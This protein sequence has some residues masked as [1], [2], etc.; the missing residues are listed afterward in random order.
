M[1]AT[2]A[3]ELTVAYKT[4]S[5]PATRAEYD[6]SLAADVPPHLPPP[7]PEPVPDPANDALPASR[8]PDESQD[9]AALRFGPVCGRARRPRRD[10]APRHCRA[11]SLHR[12]N[13]VRQG[14]NAHGPRLRS[15]HGAGG[16][17]AVPRLDAAARAGQGRERRRRRRGHR[18]VERRVW[19]RVHA[20][21]APVVV[22]L[23]SRQIAPASELSKAWDTVARQRKPSDAPEELTVLVVDVA[24]WSCRLPPN[25]SAVVRKLAGQICW[26]TA[27]RAERLRPRAGSPNAV[28]SGYGADRDARSVEDLRH[29]R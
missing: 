13:V 10:S 14:R 9:A 24:D 28:G 6:A 1:A 29:G 25:S 20:G 11:G 21:K 19:A 7:A 8:R 23:C 16:E 27:G 26:L 4:L 15:R 5:D 3:A 2:R 18:G 17:A 12:R 22:L